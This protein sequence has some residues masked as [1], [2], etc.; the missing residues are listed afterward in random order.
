[1]QVYECGNIKAILLICLHLRITLVMYDY[2]SFGTLVG[3]SLDMSE[4]LFKTPDIIGNV[5]RDRDAEGRVYDRGG[6]LLRDEDFFYR[7]DGEGNLILKSRRNVLEPP[8]TPRPKSWADRL[9][10]DKPDEKELQAHYGWQEGD[11]AY[12]WYGNGMLRSV[13]TPEGATIRFEYDALGR[14]T[15]K[16]KSV[17]RKFRF[18]FVLK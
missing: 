14:R 9:F 10:M 15:L 1:M 3:A 18:H 16:P 5:Y 6:R 8:L 12:E 4:Y 13:R 7:Y 17:I 11:T 2:D